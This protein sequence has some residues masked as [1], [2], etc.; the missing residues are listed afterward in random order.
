MALTIF[1]VKNFDCCFLMWYLEISA[2]LIIDLCDNSF[3]MQQER[4]RESRDNYTEEDIRMNHIRLLH[5]LPLHA[6]QPR[7]WLQQTWLIQSQY[8]NFEELIE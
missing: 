8:F 1:L 7:Q 4:L 3:G 6:P 5:H 2:S